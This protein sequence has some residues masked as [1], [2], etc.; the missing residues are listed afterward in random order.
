MKKYVL[1]VLLVLAL[2]GT[3]TWSQ[4]AQS[5]FVDATQLTLIGKAVPTAHPY[6]RLDT[7]VHKGLTASE[8]QQARCASGLALVFSTNSNY[9]E[10]LPKYILERKTDNVTGLASAGF[11]LY[12]KKD[13]K[14]VYVNTAVPA[15]RDAVV[16]ISDEMGTD[17]KECLLYLPVFSELQQLQVGVEANASLQAI[18]NPFKRKTVFFGSSFTQGTSASRPGM[19]YPMQVQR[20]LNLDVCNLG[21]AGNSK[22]QPYFAEIL[23]GTQADA[24]VFDAFSNPNADLIQ[25]RLE[26]FVARLVKAHPS[27]P[28]I[29]VETIFRG[30]ASFNSKIKASELAKR[31]TAKKLMNELVKRYPNVYFVPSPLTEEESHDTSADGVHPSDLGYFYWA[32]NLSKQLGPLFGKI[33]SAKP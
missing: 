32:R 18:A 10:V 9:I 29:F 33:E 11:D 24:F 25:D 22:L 20:M 16:R 26:S 5:R 21:F 28:L 8:N 15:K 14:W 1:F 19:S 4:A 30:K 27:T 7:V 13:G 23:A 2:S 12:V 3:K 6:H 17:L 31:E